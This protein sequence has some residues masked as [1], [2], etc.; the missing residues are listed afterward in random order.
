MMYVAN[1]DIKS[2]END[3]WHAVQTL[4]YEP[5]IHG[6]LCLFW[7]LGTILLGHLKTQK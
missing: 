5:E 7:W 2:I 1:Q 4:L 6:K 3:F